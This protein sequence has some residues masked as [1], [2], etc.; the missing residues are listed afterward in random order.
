MSPGGPARVT[1]LVSAERP[2]QLPAGAGKG[3]R[4]RA[5]PRSPGLRRAGPVPSIVSVT[6]GTSLLVPSLLCCRCAALRGG[7]LLGPSGAW[8]SLWRHLGPTGL[9]SG[10]ER[11]H[12]SAAGGHLTCGPLFWLPWDTDTS[13]PHHVAERPGPGLSPLF[14]KVATSQ[15]VVKVARAQGKVPRPPLALT[16]RNMVIAV[17]R[18]PSLGP[19]GCPGGS[20]AGGCGSHDRQ[21]DQPGVHPAEGRPHTVSAWPIPNGWHLGLVFGS[22]SLG[23]P[24]NWGVRSRLSCYHFGLCFA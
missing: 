13:W 10:A 19:A 3:I 2:G 17:V 21:H 22:V 12:V 20:R 14:C 23:R 7:P 24:W 18:P 6:S 15:G 1:A 9:S 4:H 5:T 11:G 8:P 16:T